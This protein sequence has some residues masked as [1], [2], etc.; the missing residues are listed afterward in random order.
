MVLR[1][2]ECGA[3]S[4]QDVRGVSGWH[5]RRARPGSMHLVDVC[6]ECHA[7]K[8]ASGS[9]LPS[10]SQ[11]HLSQQA[12]RWVASDLIVRTLPSGETHHHSKEIVYVK[13][14]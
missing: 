10:R 8:T 5:V 6:R 7:S 11:S 1:C 9:P 2:Y 4:A 14:T 3:S 13:Y 12:P